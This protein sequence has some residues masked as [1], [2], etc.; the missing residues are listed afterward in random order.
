MSHYRGL[1]ILPDKKFEIIFFD[2]DTCT[3]RFQESVGGHF[4]Q[5]EINSWL[6][7]WI[8]IN[9]RIL[10]MKDNQGAT[11]IFSFFHSFLDDPPVLKGDILCTGGSNKETGTIL[12]LTAAQID[13]LMSTANGL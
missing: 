8:N 2:D 4:E 1:K 3:E 7:L 10:K 11:R 12:G 9:S 5:V 13:F 6:S